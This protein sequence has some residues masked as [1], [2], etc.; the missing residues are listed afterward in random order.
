M[1]TSVGYAFVSQKT[2]L[3]GKTTLTYHPSCCH[4]SRQETFCGFEGHRCLWNMGHQLTPSVFWA[5]PLS[6]CCMCM[7]TSNLPRHPRMY[8]LSSSHGTDERGSLG[9]SPKLLKVSGLLCLR[10]TTL[11]ITKS[12]GTLE[13]SFVGPLILTASRQNSSLQHEMF[14]LHLP[15]QSALLKAKK[16]S[17]LPVLISTCAHTHLRNPAW[18]TYPCSGIC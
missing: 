6:H 10:A 4:L 16:R 9:R 5:F 8:A 7:T 11:L 3:S 12:T 14:G 1:P 13:S 2:K 15:G 17:D 18:Y